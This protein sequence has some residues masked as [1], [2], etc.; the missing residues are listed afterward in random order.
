MNPSSRSEETAVTDALSPK[1]D[2]NLIAQLR[3]AATRK[4]TPGELFEQRVSFV[5]SAMSENSG[6][7]REQV[8]EMVTAN[9]AGTSSNT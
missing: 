5:F 8:R 1:T 6:V 3:D 4:P 7:T 2:P 9:Q